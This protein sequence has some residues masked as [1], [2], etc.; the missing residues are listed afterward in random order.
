MIATQPILTILAQT[1]EVKKEESGE[2]NV[3]ACQ[4]LSMKEKA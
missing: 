1:S 3:A 4:S 2:K